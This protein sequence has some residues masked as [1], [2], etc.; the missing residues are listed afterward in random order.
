MAS[1]I[2]YPTL[3]KG[4]A[5]QEEA[6]MG[7]AGGLKKRGEWSSNRPT[8]GKNLEKEGKNTREGSFVTRKTLHTREEKRYI[9]PRREGNGEEEKSRERKGRARKGRRPIFEGKTIGGGTPAT[10]R[11]SRRLGGS[12]AGGGN[13][14]STRGG[15]GKKPRVARRRIPASKL[16]PTKTNS[17]HDIPKKSSDSGREKKG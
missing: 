9:S 1:S 16:L 3:K 14:I 8:G 15:D 17:N 7:L 13:E 6:Q 11:Q 10:H 4:R 2:P 12:E 5:R